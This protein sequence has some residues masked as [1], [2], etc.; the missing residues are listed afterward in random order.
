M[1]TVKPVPTVPPPITLSAAPPPAVRETEITGM[2]P[3]LIGTKVAVAP[4]A[5]LKLIEPSLRTYDSSA[6]I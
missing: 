3:S 5:W 6:R 2:L 4:V 1:G